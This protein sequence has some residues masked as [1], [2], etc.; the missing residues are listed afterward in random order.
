MQDKHRNE[1]NE[2]NVV[3]VLSFKEGNESWFESY[4]MQLSLYVCFNEGRQDLRL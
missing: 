2:N 3:G 1:E 4:I